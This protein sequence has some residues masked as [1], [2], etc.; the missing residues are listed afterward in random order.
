MARKQPYDISYDQATKKHLRA[1]EAKYHSLIRTAIEE[2]LQHEPGKDTRN[3][4]PLRQPAP[5]EATWEIRFGPDNCFRVLY[6][7]DE[8]HR[9]VQIQA[10]GVKE[11]NRLLVAGKEVEL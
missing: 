9:Q 10:I 11:G 1:I 8:E 5:F 2:Q 6:G 4:K 7:I 3:R